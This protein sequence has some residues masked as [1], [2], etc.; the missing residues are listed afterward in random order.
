MSLIYVV[1]IVTYTSQLKHITVTPD[2]YRKL[3]E[4]GKFGESYNDVI[5]RLL[6]E[7][8]RGSKK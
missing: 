8:E 6:K 5:V 3:K 1:K 4:V 7:Q 2:T